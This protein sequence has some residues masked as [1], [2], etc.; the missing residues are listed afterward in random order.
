LPKRA[1]WATSRSPWSWDTSIS[2]LTGA[3]GTAATITRSRIRRSRSSVKRRG[4]CPVSMTLSTTP[5]T[6]APS[7]AANASTTSSSKE[8]GV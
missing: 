8:S 6:A 1:A 3:S 2:P 5:N 4:S 7:P